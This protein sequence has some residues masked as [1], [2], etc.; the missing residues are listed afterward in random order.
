MSKEEKADYLHISQLTLDAETGWSESDN[1][2]KGHL[3]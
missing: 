2:S 1:M 3:S